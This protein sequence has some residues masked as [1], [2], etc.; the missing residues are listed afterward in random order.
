MDKQM[1]DL[2]PSEMKELDKEVKAYIKGGG[3]MGSGIF[4][5]L[6]NKIKK[7]RKKVVK[8]AKKVVVAGVEKATGCKDKKTHDPYNYVKKPNESKHQTFKAKD[9][10]LYSAKWSGP[11]TMVLPKIAELYSKHGSVSE[12]IKSSMFS[13]PIDRQAMAHDIAYLLAGD[14]E[15]KDKKYQMIRTADERF[16]KRLSKIKDDKFNTTIP[17]NAMKAKIL[18]EKAGGKQYSGEEPI[19][20]QEQRDRAKALLS[21]L[22]RSGEGKKKKDSGRFDAIIKAIQEGSGYSSTRKCGCPCDCKLGRGKSSS[23]IL[24]DAVEASEK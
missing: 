19:K 1:K 21:A 7:H 24:D 15:D 12:M 18:F 20:S 9:G 5:K 16:V 3:Q 13:N 8:V 11:G 2:S 14:E 23:E 4:R 10:C 17:L 6:I 22:Q